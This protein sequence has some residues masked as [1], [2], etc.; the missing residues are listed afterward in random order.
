MYYASVFGPG[1]TFI[2]IVSV[3]LVAVSSRVGAVVQFV[4]LCSLSF[5]VVG[6]CSNVGAR[7]RQ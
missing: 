4:Q 2:M 7:G 6:Q 5:E 3:R 1:R